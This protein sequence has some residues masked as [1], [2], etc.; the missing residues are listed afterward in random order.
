MWKS[1]FR[2]SLGWCKRIDQEDLGVGE[3]TSSRDASAG[4]PS[5]LGSSVACLYL[6]IVLLE[7]IAITKIVIKAVSFCQDCHRITWLSS[8]LGRSIVSE[9]TVPLQYHRWLL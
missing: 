1:T 5:C 3:L 8:Q 2:R 6:K 4:E 9:S 7:K